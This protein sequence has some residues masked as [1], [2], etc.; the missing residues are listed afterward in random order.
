MKRLI[1]IQG[2]TRA[3][4]LSQ[5]ALSESQR[6]TLDT[7]LV[8]HYAHRETDKQQDTHGDLYSLKSDIMTGTT[9]T[10]CC[11]ATAPR[12]T[13]APIHQPPKLNSM[14]EKRLVNI[15]A[16]AATT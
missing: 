11:E 4:S 6:N 13:E 9:C 3:G 5:H 12:P 1:V 7:E 14:L 15:A 16:A 2:Q 10:S 8:Y